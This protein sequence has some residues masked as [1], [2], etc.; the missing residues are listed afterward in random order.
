[1]RSVSVTDKDGKAVKVSK[2][3]DGTYSL[4]DARSN[5]TVKV[6]FGCD[7]G[8]VVR[9]PCIYRRLSGPV[10]SRRNRLGR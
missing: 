9:Q 1:M 3:A 5:V 4:T 10:V 8:E 2:A 7:G 6:V